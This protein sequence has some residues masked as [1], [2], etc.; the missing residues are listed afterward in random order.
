MNDV[1]KTSLVFCSGFHEW[2]CDNIECSEH[3]EKKLFDNLG[4]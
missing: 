4:D 1:D 2:D 3:P